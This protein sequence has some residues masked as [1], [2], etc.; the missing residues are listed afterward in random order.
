MKTGAGLAGNIT[1]T[2]ANPL[3]AAERCRAIRFDRTAEITTCWA[4]VLAREPDDVEALQQCQAGYE[5]MREAGWNDISKG[6]GNPEP[7][8]DDELQMRVFWTRWNELLSA[9]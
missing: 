6:M 5:N 9:G 7:Q 1:G 3:S 2:G 4:G 8:Y